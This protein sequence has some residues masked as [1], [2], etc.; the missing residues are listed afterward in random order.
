MSTI[1]FPAKSATSAPR[2]TTLL[3]STALAGITLVTT[4]AVAQEQLNGKKLG[5]AAVREL[6]IGANTER[7]SMSDVGEIPFAI[8]VDGE[9]VD[10]S[11]TPAV[12]G[13]RPAVAQESGGKAVKPVDQQR[14]TDLALHRVDIN[15]KY[16]GLQA[17]PML[18]VSTTPMRRTY[19]AG[20]PVRFL[21]TS[22]YPGFIERSEI[23]I[24]EMD[25]TK[26]TRNPVAVLPVS[27]NGEAAWPM[28]SSEEMHEFSYV[29]RVYDAQGRFDE[30]EPL[31][32]ARSER[33][34]KPEKKPEAFA[35]GMGEDRTA[36]RN[37]PIRGGAVT[38]Y[39]NH[40]PP[41]FEVE[42][43][44]ETIPVDKNQGFVVQRIL[45]PGDHDVDIGLNGVSKSGGLN[46]NRQI[47]IPDDDWF[48]VGLADLTIGK[49]TG[50]DNIETVR[51]GEY[52]EVYSKGRLAFYL[53]GKIK[54]EYLLTAAADSGEDDLEDLFRNL[55]EKDPR[56]LLRRL[57]P[58]DYYPVYGDD[59]TFV[60]D[61]PT[62]GKFYIRL[63]RGDSHVMWGNYKTSVT[64]TE[65]L[66]QERGLYGAHAAYRSEASTSFGERQTEVT[67]YAAQPDTLP[68][69]EEFLATG[70]SAYFMKRQDI[71]EGS[72][73][74]TVE[75]RDEIT[76]RVIERRVLQY[77]EDYSFDYIQGVL[78]LRRPLSSTAGTSGPV[79]DGAL[80]GNKVYLNAQ[81]EYTPVA[82]DVDGYAYGGRAQHWVNDKVRV[83]VT[84]MEESTGLADQQA[85]G[86]DVK[87]RH[88]E[89]T[90]VEAEVAHSKGPGFGMSRSTDGG[91]TNSDTAIAGSPGQSASAWRVKGQFDL[92][93]LSDGGMK[94][95]VGGYYENKEAGFSTL[96]DQLYVD[97]RIWGAHAD[98]DLTD[99]VE[100]KL[101]YDDFHDDAGQIK[102]EGSS[103]LSYQWDQYWKI[104]FG[105]TYTELMSPLA[106]AAGKSGYDG[107]RLDAGVR[108][109]Y[110]WDEDLLLYAFGQGTVD[111]S[112]DISRNDRVG[113]GTEMQLTDKIGAN[114]EISY[115]THGVGG[116]AALTYDPNADDHYYIGY[117]L[118]PDR[119]FDLDRTYDLVGT[120]KGAIVAGAKRKM[121]DVASAYA[122][123]SYDMFG[124]RNSL[125][126]TYGIVYTPDDIWTI[127]GG[128]EAGRVRDETIDRAGIQRSDFD[129]YAPSLSIGYKDE[130]AG[131]AARLRGEVRIED[132][133]D[134]TRDQNTYLMAAGVS[135]KTSEDW[136]LLANIDAV[137]S[138]AVS[139]V[140]SFQDTDYVEAS[141][142]YAYRPID[143]D[144]LNILF[145]YTWLYDMPGNNQLVSG[146]TGD[147]LAPAQRSQILSADLIYDL[148]PWLSVGG[149][150]GYRF[151]EVRYR[152]EGGAGSDFEDDWQSS[153]AHLGILRADLHVVNNWDVL[154]EGRVMHMPEAE[155]TD[156]GALVAVYRHVG[157]NF[158]VGVGYNFGNFSD[159]LRDLTLDDEGIFLNAVGKF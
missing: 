102:R 12:K 70:G 5:A 150:Y 16:D 23:R 151:G 63:E 88:S 128:F 26:A 154:L 78:I 137:V 101:T 42:A 57:D 123:S 32:L 22:N 108:V 96:Y 83:G 79:R 143:N 65:F 38:I 142:G 10:K 56:Q 99:K 100:A 157:N 141:L 9:T 109:D 156:L 107:S 155:T 97:K 110:R 147:V 120:D 121:D 52:D 103:S 92:A 48:Y 93:D 82:S 95:I 18:N 85:L 111:R 31:T 158:K 133:D 13:A 75:I 149:K 41:G 146:S 47:N 144:R 49:K 153:S 130:E 40:V 131:I 90:F 134:G 39:G 106:I 114:A 152:T 53:K 104:S 4:A 17:N 25:G 28:S 44:G 71:V 77:G 3:A 7:E 55:D 159:D 81:Y 84:G 54:G 140:T 50:D 113:V 112:G 135:W 138:D 59:S 122:E 91:L 29:L 68:H 24:Y 15:I 76:G 94:G 116:L 132:S 19:R 127:D 2:F 36:I 129:R 30:T 74:V 6:P 117:K 11:E 61:A 126:Q 145:K 64:G 8:S 105:V 73:T 21:A 87:I 136:R 62:K 86:A 66:R 139:T 34:L 72:E 89:T 37:I 69:R 14:Q 35:P 60:E 1:R 119:A 115:G 33:E 20:E 124:Q 51:P 58:D 27:I 125:T 43:M 67:V 148:F 80:G 98:V 45:P 118:D 46:F